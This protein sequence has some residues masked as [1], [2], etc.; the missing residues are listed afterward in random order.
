MRLD[1][2]RSSLSYLYIYI[3][4]RRVKLLPRGKAPRLPR[5]APPPLPL[6]TS[7]KT[8][9]SLSRCHRQECIASTSFLWRY[10]DNSSCRC[11]RKTVARRKTTVNVHPVRNETTV[12]QKNTGSGGLRTHPLRWWRWGGG[13]STRVEKRGELPVL[14]GDLI[15]IW[16]RCYDVCGLNTWCPLISKSG[17]VVWVIIVIII[18]MMMVVVISVL[19]SGSIKVGGEP[20]DYSYRLSKIVKKTAANY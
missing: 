5:P 18:T 10:T 17:G 8:R 16:R 2:L 3:Y 11:Q 15:Y 6:R 4:T 9:P 7:H 19:E 13:G 12:L 1:S 14:W 20:G